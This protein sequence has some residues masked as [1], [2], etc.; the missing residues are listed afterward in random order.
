MKNR[1]ATAEVDSAYQPTD[2]FS[3]DA[4]P[5]GQYDVGDEHAN[6]G[7]RLPVPA[8]QKKPGIAVGYTHSAIAYSRQLVIPLARVNGRTR[9]TGTQILTTQCDSHATQLRLLERHNHTQP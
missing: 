2:V 1:R 4:E 9:M 8:G 7:T 6:D 3:G 5:S